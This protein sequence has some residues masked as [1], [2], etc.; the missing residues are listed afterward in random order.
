MDQPLVVARF[1]HFAATM[2]LFGAAVFTAALAPASV[3]D[4]L[5]PLLRRLG[6]PLAALSLASAV[7]WLVLVARDMAGGDLDFET[8]R[9]VLT[10]TGFGRVWFGR[11]ALLLLLVLATLRRGRRWRLPAVLAGAA[12]ASLGLV[13]HAAMQ[14]GLLGAAHRLNHAVHLLAASGWLGGLPAFLVCLSL[15]LRSRERGDALRAMMAY[16]HAGHFAVATLLASGAL[17]VAMTSGALPWPPDTPWRVGL[18]AKI[19]VFAAMTALALVNRYVLAPRIG[20]SGTAAKALAAGAAAEIA[21]ALT[22]IALASGF[23]TYD[24]HAR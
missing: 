22:A 14:D 23:A 9:T 13:G 24:P 15:Y 3:A 6:L 7:A 10:D 18:D 4:E 12:T 5:S 21:L 11:L 16:S 20:R 17:D 1:V 2:T 8:L 19:M